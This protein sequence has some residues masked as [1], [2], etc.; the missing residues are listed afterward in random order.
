[1]IRIRDIQQGLRGLVG[2]RQ[3]LDPSEAIDPLLEESYSGLYFQDA[4]P[5]LTVENLKA[6][7]PDM[8]CAQYPEWN[9]A[10]AYTAGAKVRTGEGVWVA[11]QEN[12]GQMPGTGSEYW[13]AYNPLSDY[14]ARLTDG[15]ISAVVQTFLQMKQLNK[16]TRN[17]LERR[18]FFDGAGRIKATEQNRH[19]IVG[20]EIVPIR[21]MGVTTKIER[22]GLQMYGGT[23]TV[24]LYLF[25]SSQPEPVRTFELDYTLQNGGYQWFTLDNCHLPYISEG[26]NAGGAWYL[27]YDQDELPFGMEA[28]NVSKDWSREPCGTCNIGSLESWRAITKFMQIS[29]FMYTAPQTFAE[30]P[31]LWDIAA[32]I[33]TNTS[34]YGLNCE[35]TVGCDLTD[36]II[37]QRGIFATVLQRQVA[38][39]ALRTIALNPSVRV[40]RN[41]SNATR[42]E[43]LYEID[44]DPQ[45]RA[46]GLAYELRE[47]Y[48]ALSIDTSGIDRA[49]LACNNRGVRYTT[50]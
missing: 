1:M 17:L 49:C 35:V 27:C 4:H 7:M 50:A 31:Q 25:H 6:V 9:A 45:G 48:K 15:G 20:Y 32:N 36:F 5:M 44:G 12:T 29:P 23:G 37:S 38:A 10:A 28:V 3:P 19:R 46:A 16:E 47:A 11:L 2:W 43:L 8:W 13:K 14:L 26:N 41:Q 34:N 24:K 18:T 22:V 21:A 33:Y 40:N 30:N 42:P 39:T